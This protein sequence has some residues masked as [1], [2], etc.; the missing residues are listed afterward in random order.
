MLVSN[1]LIVLFSPLIFGAELQKLYEIQVKNQFLTS[2]TYLTF[3]HHLLTR[4]VYHGFE[5]FF[6]R[7]IGRRM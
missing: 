7:F 4:S 2:N 3:A 1:I 6:L 5:N